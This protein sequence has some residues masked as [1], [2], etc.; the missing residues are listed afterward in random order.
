MNDFYDNH[1]HTGIRYFI[2]YFHYNL[3]NNGKDKSRILI[4]I[5]M[6]VCR[7]HMFSFLTYQ[8]ILILIHLQTDLLS[9]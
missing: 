8:N 4:E 1:A 2:N 5:C 3:G 6:M 7:K 9:I